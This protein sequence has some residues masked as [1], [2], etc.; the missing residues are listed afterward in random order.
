VLSPEGVVRVRGESWSA[1]SLNGNLPAG[2]VVQVID[3]KGIR[4]EVWGE[5]EASDRTET[6][7]T[8][9]GA[10]IDGEATVAR[11][12]QGRAASS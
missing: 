7:A 10:E 11:A 8:W 5:D 9:G 2:A 4:L 6:V 1:T 3:S 12:G